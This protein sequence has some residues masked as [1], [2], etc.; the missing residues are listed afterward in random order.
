MPRLVVGLAVL[1]LAL[2]ASPVCAQGYSV[3]EH[4]P[5]VMG[6]G[7]AGVASP[8]PD[9]SSVF[10]NPAGI[11]FTESQQLSFGA[12]MIRAVGDFTND[13]TKIK[14]PL[15]DKTQPV[16]AGYY[17]R[18]I[19]PRFAAGLGVF[20]PYGLTT[21]WG[22]SFEGRYLAYKSGL[23]GLY[24][25]PTAA[26]RIN[27]RVAVGL[28]VDITRLSVG[29]R[30]RADLSEVPLTGM[31][32]VTFGM[33]GVPAGTDFADLE[34]EGHGWGVGVHVGVQAKVTERVA[35][36]ARYLSGQKVDIGSATVN[37]TQIMTG[38]RL[39][40]PLGPGIPAGT[41]VDALLASQ[42]AEGGALSDQDATTELPLPAQLVLGAAF[43]VA[44]QAKLF[45]DYQFT[46]WSAFDVLVVDQEI[47]P[48]L[49]NVEDYNNTHAFRAGVEYQLTPKAVVRGGF[50]A[51]GAASPDQTVTPLLPE[52][53]RREYTVGFG[54]ELARGVRF[55]IAYQYLDQSD[56]A[57]RTTDGGMA[58]PTVAVNNGVYRFTAHLV[59][60]GVAFS[61]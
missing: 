34:L 9:G 17:V 60:F 55:D 39:P 52:G 41:P 44:P 18:R 45:V 22:E 23:T 27:D 58:V 31:P 49:V 42:F 50:L 61:F 26:Y 19:T 6:R 24:I 54:T 3:Y 11:A 53:P 29:L 25:Q 14:S 4:S 2:T 35:L 20:V 12:T 40:I 5:C 16:P 37:T 33:L 38:F 21:E 13:Q 46:N 8:C 57:G 28:G 10:F 1:A 56:R 15:A 48:D 30:Q 47:G 36:G 59:G 7:G 32:N 51:H 43:D